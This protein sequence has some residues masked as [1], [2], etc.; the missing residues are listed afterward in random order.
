[1]VEEWLAYASPE[2][3]SLFMFQ[4]PRSAKRLFFDV[5]PRAVDEYVQFATC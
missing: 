4:K 2:S 5:I 1:S 3:L